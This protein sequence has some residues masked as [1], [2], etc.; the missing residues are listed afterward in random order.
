MTSSGNGPDPWKGLAAFYKACKD[1][2]KYAEWRPSAIKLVKGGSH[3]K[4]L[5][6]TYHL[7]LQL[8]ANVLLKAGKTPLF[9]LGSVAVVSIA[10]AYKYYK[11]V[12]DHKKLAE[13]DKEMAALHTE[14][15]TVRRIHMAQYV[16][17]L[18][19]ARR[20]SGFQKEGYFK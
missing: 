16:V 2:R 13:I 3:T 14:L 5:L 1:Y 4:K 6:S 7:N 15:A 19:E 12:Q 8:G 18:Y 9:R 11:S 20:F 10:A 17:M